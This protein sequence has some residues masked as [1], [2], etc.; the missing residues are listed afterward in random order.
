MVLYEGCRNLTIHSFPRASLGNKL[1]RYTVPRTKRRHTGIRRWLQSDNVNDD[2][3]GNALGTT[4]WMVQ[5]L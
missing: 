5:L 2:E 3:T 1:L 4:S